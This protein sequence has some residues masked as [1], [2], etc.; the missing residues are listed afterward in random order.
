MGSTDPG[1]RVPES[2]DLTEL[3]LDDLRLARRQAER[4]GGDLSYVRRL[5]H[6]RIDIIKAELRRREG[7]GDELIAS[8]PSILADTPSGAKVSKGRHVSID[9][10]DLNHPVA[11]EA[12]NAL[13]SLSTTNFS[14]VS[15]E[16]LTRAVEAL[17]AHER[18]VSEAR[19]QLHKKIDGMSSE[20]TRRYREGSAQVDDLLAAARRP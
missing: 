1:S 13:G 18:S 14:A 12:H 20:L 11:Q 2:I 8:L 19:T 9:D 6:G 16:E 7:N 10:A 5:L 4:D 15:D 3:T 17:T